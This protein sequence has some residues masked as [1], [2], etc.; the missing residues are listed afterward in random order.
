MSADKLL[1]TPVFVPGA[2]ALLEFDHR[3]NLE[4]VPDVFDPSL[5]YYYDGAVLEIKIGAASSP[6]SWRQAGASSAGA[7][8][9]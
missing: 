4:T 7:T 8:T 9:P 1:D 3:H 2:G 6:T 5:L